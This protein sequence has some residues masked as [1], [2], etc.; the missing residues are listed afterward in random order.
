MRYL[1]N[2]LIFI[3]MIVAPT[4][5][6]MAYEHWPTERSSELVSPG[7]GISAND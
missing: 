7:S 4:V 1:V 3:A 5:G 6:A 2:W